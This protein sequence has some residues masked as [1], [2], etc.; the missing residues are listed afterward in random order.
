MKILPVK[1]EKIMRNFKKLLVVIC[2]LAF[3]TAG[4]VIAAF[5]ANNTASV[6]ELEALV[7]AAEGENDAVAK[8]NAVVAVKD[9]I[10]AHKITE[11][12]EGYEALVARAHTVSVS[13]AMA[14]LNSV[15]VNGVK[16]TTAYDYMIKADELLE[17][18]EL[19]D[20]VAG[21][22]D[23]KEKYD[24]ALVRAAGVLNNACDANIETTLT[25]AKNHG[26]IS[27]ARNLYE[28]CEPFG[29][30]SILYDA[31]ADFMILEKAHENALSKNY[32][33]L[34]STNSIT[35]YDLKTFFSD[36][37]E[38][39]GIGSLKGNWHIDLKGIANTIGTKK[40]DNGNKYLS[41]TYLEK[42]NPAAS[43]AQVSLGTLK[44]DSSEG[45]VFEFDITTFSTFPESGIHIETGSVA[46]A[47]FPP[48][49]FA[50]NNE[51]KIL[52]NDKSTVIFEDAIVPGQWT[53]I[54][55]VLD[56]EDF[57]YKLYVEGQYIATYDAKYQ[58]VT[59]YDHAQVAFRISGN[60]ST[61]GEI[62]V[63]NF[64]IYGG[65]SYRIHDRLEKMTQDE[66]FLYYVDYLV[67]EANK[68][69]DRTVAYNTAS[70]LLEN[71]W[72][73]D[74]EGYGTYTDY[75][76][77]NPDLMNAVD[78]Y[79][80]FDLEGF[81]AE[82]GLRNLDSY[83]ALVEPLAA[84]ERKTETAAQRS[85]AISDIA[86]FVEKNSD[87]INRVADRDGNGKTDFAEYEAIVNQITREAR[88]DANAADFIRYIDRFEKSMTFSAKQRN[89]NFAYELA[90][91]DGIDVAL[92]LDETN[93]AREN[94]TALVEAFNIYRNADK[95]IYELNKTNNSNKIVKCIDLI[96]EYTTE[97]EWLANREYMEEYLNLLKDIVLNLDSYG[98]LQ[99]DPEFEGVTEAIEFF[100][101]SYSFF[102]ALLQDE[103]VA[104]IQGVLDR[105]AATDAYIEKLGMVS[106]LE[107]YVTVND[108]DYS[109]ERIL[110][111]LNDIDTCKAEL[112]LRKEDYA[113]IL[114]Q[115]AVYFT[116][117]V[118]RMR[119]AQTYN[120]QREYYEQ[121][122]ELYFNIDITVDGAERAVEIF[123]EYKVNL[124]RIAESSVRFIEAVAIYRAC[125]T[126]DEKYAALVECYYNAQ[127]V[128]MSY[129]GAEEAMAEYLAAYN[130]YMGYVNAVNED[131]AVTGNAIGS[132]RANCGITNVIA[133]IV[134]KLF[135]V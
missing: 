52:S 1:K 65:D 118:E 130:A 91:N 86:L 82:V 10:K 109:D 27:R 46:G 59:K 135:G 124:D 75:T 70:K 72:V 95:V 40:E 132:L 26:P 35:N 74:S 102:Y 42:D 58:G 66:Q 133:V 93:P 64:K 69:G 5:A 25:T 13:G 3:L 94:F 68:V 29:D 112:Q 50:L 38:S 113:K 111:L 106:G 36:D 41:H 6:E 98:A 108:I 78:T 62:C 114:K 81:L 47:Y 15:D 53:H 116:N 120:E 20:D 7:A 32:K 21:Y 28:K 85:Q 22:A 134:K 128:E 61:Y 122:Y 33:T 83:I 126:E 131:I 100:N 49:Y 87:M 57:V 71:Y 88:Y 45:L 43:Y 103:H 2:V 90:E 30:A 117:L 44:V 79:V 127:F 92:I 107:K 73:V 121:A 51:G 80:A 39:Y 67:N 77:E 56:P 115:N 60:P 9:Y 12:D 11:S 19:S 125:E 105:V 17:L 63:D 24:S 97:E 110:D 16:A 96:N 31:R 99:Y 129:D 123:D 54:V 84:I 76:L 23:A 101:A 119:T 89:Y 34:D 48:P 55:L 4:C 18:F 8:Y 104:H 14:L 37:F